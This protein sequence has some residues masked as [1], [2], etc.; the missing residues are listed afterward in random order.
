MNQQIR[1]GRWF[2]LRRE[3]KCGHVSYMSSHAGGILD[4]HIEDSIELQRKGRCF[5][6][7]FWP[8]IWHYAQMARK[9]NGYNLGSEQVDKNG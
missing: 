3:K 9:K 4:F 6:C 1:I 8:S 2:T 5:A 7:G